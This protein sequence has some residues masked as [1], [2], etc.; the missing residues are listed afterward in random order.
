MGVP[1]VH[2]RKSYEVRDGV[3]ES[4]CRGRGYQTPEDGLGI[5][6]PAPLPT[7]FHIPEVCRQIYSET[8]TLAYSLNIFVLCGGAFEVWTKQM[9]DFPAHMCA[10]QNV[11]MNAYILCA[12]YERKSAN[13]G[14]IH[15]RT[16][17]TG[18]TLLGAFPGLKSIRMS[19]RI[20]CDRQQIKSMI[21]KYEGEKGKELKVVF[22]R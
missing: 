1:Y 4:L 21:K 20:S 18:R 15:R 11:E 19:P 6:Q 22:R 7:A 13:F 16:R 14:W 17:P 12:I 8:A 5:S 9:Q 2:I 3:G 10:V